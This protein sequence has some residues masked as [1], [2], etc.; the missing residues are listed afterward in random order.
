MPRAR[1]IRNSEPFFSIIVTSKNDAEMLENLCKQLEQQTFQDFELI[2]VPAALPDYNVTIKYADIVLPM[3]SDSKKRDIHE[4]PKAYNEAIREVTGKYI[5]IMDADLMFKDTKQLERIANHIKKTDYDIYTCDIEQ[6][7][8]KSICHVES[9]INRL[10]R[11]IYPWCL[12]V[13]IFK[14][15]FVDKNFSNENF[16]PNVWTWDVR[17]SYKLIARGYNVHLIN[18]SLYHLR[19][20][21]NTMI[22]GF[23]GIFK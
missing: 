16:C 1:V 19:D 2:I 7:N 4:V 10:V 9:M 11:N 13:H 3:F 12:Q 18:E 21:N 8:K 23:V 22:Q 5:I 14:K 20:Y 17:L 15:S 6:Y